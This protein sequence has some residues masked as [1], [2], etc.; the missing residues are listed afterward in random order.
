MRSLI[1]AT[2]IGIAASDPVVGQSERHPLVTKAVEV[3]AS[4]MAVADM[5]PG[6]STNPA[7]M[8]T[9]LTGLSLANLS[10]QLEREEAAVMA[11]K[12]QII[13]NARQDKE[14]FCDRAAAQT[15]DNPFRNGAKMPLF[16]KAP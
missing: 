13:D 11:L 8:G 4:G 12:S 5:C 6:Y 3:I 1:W 14:Q 15:M 7:V 2:F 10:H 16:V 9:V